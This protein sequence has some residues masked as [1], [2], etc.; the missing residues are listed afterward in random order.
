MKEVI[1]SNDAP[2]A[3]GPYSQATRHGDM[4]FLSGN[5]PIEPVS[6]NIPADIQ[7]QTRQV[8][9]NMQHV[10]A[11]AGCTMDDVVKTT[12]FLADMALFQD[13][14]AVYAEFFTSAP[15]ARAT[16]AAKALPR[17]VLVEIE[18]IAIRKR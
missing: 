8:L 10:L 13:M 12:C 18:A 17:D 16:V 14:N 3:I 9:T 5:L 7:G 2:A 15:P 11:A 4:V 6:G 1:S